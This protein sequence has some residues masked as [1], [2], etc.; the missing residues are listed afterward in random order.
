[1]ALLKATL[2]L[3]SATAS[4]HAYSFLSCVDYDTAHDICYG[5]LAQCGR[6]ADIPWLVAPLEAAIVAR[7]LRSPELCMCGLLSDSS[8]RVCMCAGFMRNYESILPTASHAYNF[9]LNA[10]NWTNTTAPA[11]N[12]AS[13]ADV[14]V[15]PTLQVGSSVCPVSFRVICAYQVSVNTQTCQGVQVPCVTSAIAECVHLGSF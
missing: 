14:A 8:A 5:V 4:T 6:A 13:Q 1:M 3:L 9:Q 12:A 2:L 10:Y 15:D 7:L 11:T